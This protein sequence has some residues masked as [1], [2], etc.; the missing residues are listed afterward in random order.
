MLVGGKGPGVGSDDVQVQ[1]W[2]RGVEAHD[3]A[4]GEFVEVAGAQVHIEVVVGGAGGEACV[5]GG[6][7]SA[8]HVAF[9][10]AEVSDE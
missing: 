4:V 1:V 3:V 10:V 5:V 6:D 2:F 8:E 7:A 9:V